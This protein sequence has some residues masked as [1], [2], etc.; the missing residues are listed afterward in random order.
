MLNACLINYLYIYTLCKICLRHK[1]QHS[2][3]ASC[4]IVQHMLHGCPIYCLYIYSLCKICLLQHS[5]DASCDIQ[6]MLHACLINYLY[7]SS[8]IKILGKLNRAKVAKPKLLVFVEVLL[9]HISKTL[10]IKN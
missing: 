7:T 8:I 1:C 10:K 9:K 6:H 5:T 2:T 3:E 4:D